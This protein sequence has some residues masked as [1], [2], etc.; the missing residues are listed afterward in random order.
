MPE[1]PFHIY[2]VIETNELSAG[3]LQEQLNDLTDDEFQIAYSVGTKLILQRESY[4]TR[5]GRLNARFAK[6]ANNTSPL[7]PK[8]G[9]PLG[10]TSPSVGPI[11]VDIQAN[12]D[13]KEVLEETQKALL[14]AT[15]VPK[16][17]FYRG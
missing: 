2:R 14:N 10:P 7:A 8:G 11:K 13:F 12:T 1:Q 3:Q 15:M 9:L 4:L 6:T 16:E 5:Q 17:M